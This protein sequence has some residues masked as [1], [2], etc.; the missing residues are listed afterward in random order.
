MLTTSLLLAVF[1]GAL[2]SGWHC[3]LMCGGIAAAIERPAALE[4][5]LRAKSEIFYLQLIMH[6][7]RVT[8]YV[9]LGALAAWIGV[10]VWQQSFLPIQRSLF[11]LTS[12]LLIYMGLRLLGLGKSKGRTGGRW[13]STQIASYWAKYLG[14]FASGPSRWFSGML[15]G[16]VPCGLV[17]SVLPL[18]FLSGDVV[19][20]AA[21]MLAFGLGTL[22]NLLLISKFS[23]A[24]TQFAQYVWVRYFAVLLLFV[25]GS[26]GL[27]R[28]WV[29]PE[30]LLKGGFCIA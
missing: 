16:L 8:S 6:L 23:A 9:L 26:F 14:R 28:A 21:L 24:L 11:V 12:L 22:P 10:V 3:A 15:W 7:G 20:G 13:L 18:A 4:T 5:P 29:L 2:V 27:Y 30:A 1:L 19:T 17:Y 25:A